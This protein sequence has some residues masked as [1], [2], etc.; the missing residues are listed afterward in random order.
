MFIDDE[1]PARDHRR[2]EGRAVFYITVTALAA[3]VLMIVG[4]MN[5]AQANSFDDTPTVLQ[6][7][8]GETHVSLAFDHADT[9]ATVDLTTTASIKRNEHDASS[10]I[11]ER[12][13]AALGLAG[14]IVVAGVSQMFSRGMHRSPASAAPWRSEA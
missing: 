4:L 14:F 3:C 10:T 13:A 9:D 2:R 6:G 1:K 11:D 7:E 12:L 5:V 8:I